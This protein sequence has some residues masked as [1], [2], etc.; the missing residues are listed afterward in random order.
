MHDTTDVATLLTHGGWA[1]VDP[2]PT[3][4]ANPDTFEMPTADELAALRPGS[5]VKAMFRCVTIAD[6]VTDGL[7]PYDAE[8]RPQLVSFVERMWLTVVETSGTPDGDVECVLDNMP[9]STHCS[10]VPGTGLKIPAHHLIATDPPADDLD[11]RGYL[12]TLARD[13]GAE[14]ARATDPVDPTALPRVHP[15]QQRRCADVGV[16]P[17]PPAMFG[18]MLV[19]SDVGPDDVPLF[20]GRFDPEPERSDVGWVVWARHASMEEAQAAAGFRVVTVQEAFRLAPAAWPWLA[21]PPHW[22]FTADADG[23]EAYPIDIEE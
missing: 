8:G 23:G 1:L 16:P 13:F 4:L 14:V 9:Y 10:L 20:G 5:L 3:A 12:A 17:H 18:S 21:L 11:L 15:D 6:E 2:R 22:G 19:A 7:A